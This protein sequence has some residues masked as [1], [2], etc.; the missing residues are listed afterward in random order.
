MRYDNAELQERLAGEY[1]VGSLQGPARRRFEALMRTRPDL[2]A[3]VEAWEDRLTP[4]AEQ[5]PPRQPPARVLRSL[6]QRISPQ[7]QETR[8]SF[9]DSLAFWRPFG[10][11][12]AVLVVLVGGYAGFILSQPEPLTQVAEGQTQDV[13]PSYIAVLEDNAEEAVVVVT[14]YKGPWRLSVKPLRKLDRAE[15]EVLQIW[16]VE[17]GNGTIRPL[18]QLASED[19]VGQPLGEDAWNAVKTSESLIVTVESGGASPTA[20]S[21]PVLFSGPCINLWESSA[22]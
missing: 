8:A 22:T 1:V 21:G 13:L 19:T 9:W 20:P 4:L 16:T 5:T 17:R 11:A 10:T 14:A 18:L 2:R 7:R 6:K 3:R 15:G 12:A